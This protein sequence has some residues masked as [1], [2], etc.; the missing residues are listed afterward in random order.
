VWKNLTGF[1]T[2]CCCTL[3]WKEILYA[4]YIKNTDPQTFNIICNTGY[5]L[6]TII[7]PAANTIKR[8]G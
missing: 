7:S 4:R 6:N 5:V 1:V 8:N 3:F 2:V